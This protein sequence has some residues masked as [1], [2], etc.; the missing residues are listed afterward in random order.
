M[1]ALL[2]SSVS[3]C[4]CG[5]HEENAAEPAMQSC[6]SSHHSAAADPNAKAVDSACI[7]YVNLPPPFV[8]GKTG[9]K[10]VK[11]EKQFPAVLPDA[12]FV[13]VARKTYGDVAHNFH[14]NTPIS[15]SRA[16]AF[17]P[18]RSPPRL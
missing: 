17:T 2:A 16:L 11:L 15:L 13:P 4:T 12:S 9:Q 3:A 5:H 7:C 10:V 1:L 8:I 14:S 18:S 6:H